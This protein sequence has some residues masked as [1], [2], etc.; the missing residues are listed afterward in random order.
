VWDSVSPGRSLGVGDQVV[1][2][3]TRLRCVPDGFV[4]A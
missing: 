3:G 2:G 1:V 4:P